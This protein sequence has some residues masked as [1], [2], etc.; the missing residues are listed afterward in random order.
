MLF[1]ELLELPRDRRTDQLL[2]ESAKARLPDVPD[3]VMTQLIVDRGT[4][5]DFQALYATLNLARI[6]WEM[7]SLPAS[8]LAAA[9]F[10]SQFDDSVNRAVQRACTVRDGDWNKV[11]K[12]PEI[13]AQWRQSRTWRV[14]PVFVEHRALRIKGGL[15]LM[16]GH[17]RFGVL[18]G[19]L[20]IGAIA[21][22]SIH[23]AWIG[24]YFE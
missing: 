23:S 19:L 16:E 14:P 3:D 22:D 11:D 13:I 15:H 2:F 6:R 18:L 12:R 10:F 20:E 9:T 8:E 1:A 24:T 21:P 17:A 7:R 4:N 5:E